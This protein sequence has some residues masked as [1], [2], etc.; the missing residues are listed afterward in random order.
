MC[1]ACRPGLSEFQQDL[2][3]FNNI[4]R[5]YVRISQFSGGGGCVSVFLGLVMK[6]NFQNSGDK[7]SPYFGDRL[8]PNPKT[9]DVVCGDI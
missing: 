5:E 9:L 4:A 8:S 1:G 7:L 2:L 3:E 6:N